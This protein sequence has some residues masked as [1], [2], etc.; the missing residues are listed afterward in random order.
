[1]CTIFG[2]VVK[3]VDSGTGPNDVPRDLCLSRDVVVRCRW[4]LGPDRPVTW[5]LFLRV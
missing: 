5:G 3:T 2:A 4:A 1:M